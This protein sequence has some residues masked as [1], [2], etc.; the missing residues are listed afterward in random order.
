VIA[1][2]EDRKR[3]EA[4]IKLDAIAKE[5]GFAKGISQLGSLQ[6]CPQKNGPP[7]LQEEEWQRAQV[8][9]VPSGVG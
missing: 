7:P 4:R 6:D 8:E 1:T 9:R 5:M 3:A 2:Q